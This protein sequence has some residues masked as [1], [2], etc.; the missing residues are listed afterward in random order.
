ME[1]TVTNLDHNGRGIS[2]IDGK[3]CF[4]ENALPSEQVE[5]EIITEKK[6]YMEATVKNIIKKSDDRVVEKCK[7]FTFC[8]G[9]NIM[10]INYNKQVDYKVNKVKEIFK[11]MC[12]MDINIDEFV[13]S[14]QYFYRNKITLHVNNNKI[15]L[16]KEKTSEII[17]IDECLICN[18]KINQIYNI[19]K[20]QDLKNIENIIIRSSKRTNE[21]M[22]IFEINDDINFDFFANLL[23]NSVDTLVIK[24]NDYYKTIFGKGYICEKLDKLLFKISPDSFFQVNTEQA[25]KLYFKVKDYLG[26]NDNVLDLYCGT[27]T[28][29]IFVSDKCLNV[30]GIEINKYAIK[31]ANENKKINNISNINFICDDSS[32][33]LKKIKNDF[34]A[35]I[36]DPPRSGLNKDMIHELF[37]ILPKK[38][39]YVSCDPVTLARDINYLLEQYNFKKIS[40]VD[41]FPN[42]SHIES[43]VLLEKK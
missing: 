8:G 35:V 12:K 42:T 31:D 37:K 25:E 18:N 20:K 10:H 6:K 30:V 40:L 17:E 11:R 3:I 9:C 29:G 23:V 19:L 22:V 26:N 5:I 33:A 32:N 36:V 34:D 43:V 2:K 38:I 41:M 1:V 28:I 24:K 4:I 27:G 16:Y 21:C 13:K 39:I 7:Y 15:G 14:E